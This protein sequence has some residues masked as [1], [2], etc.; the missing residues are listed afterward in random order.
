[1][2][3]RIPAEKGK[4]ADDEKKVWFDVSQSIDNALKGWP[5][6][7]EKKGDITSNTLTDVDGTTAAADKDWAYV[8]FFANFIFTPAS[9]EKE[10]PR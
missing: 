10:P 6:V 5:G 7:I 2:A 3:S 9:T 4:P 1:M 8:V